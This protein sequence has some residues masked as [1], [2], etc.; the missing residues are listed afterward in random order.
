MATWVLLNQSLGREK[1]DTTTRQYPHFLFRVLKVLVIF[2]TSDTAAVLL[3]IR[4]FI[5]FYLL[6]KI[7]SLISNLNSLEGNSTTDSV[8]NHKATNT[9]LRGRLIKYPASRYILPA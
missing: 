1:V 3:I 5:I 7:I 6:D 8:A 9:N 4:L 2:Q